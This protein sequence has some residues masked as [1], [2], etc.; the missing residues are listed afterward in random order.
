MKALCVKCLKKGIKNEFENEMVDA[1]G[2]TVIKRSCG[3]HSK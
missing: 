3:N 1:I 2:R